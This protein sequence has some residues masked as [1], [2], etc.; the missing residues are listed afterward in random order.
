MRKYAVSGMNLIGA[1]L[2]LFGVF[3]F[4]NSFSNKTFVIGAMKIPASADLGFLL[5]VLGMILFGLSFIAG[6]FL[7]QN[8]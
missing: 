2:I 5:I 1:L 8:R 7:R 4:A 6:K 3:V